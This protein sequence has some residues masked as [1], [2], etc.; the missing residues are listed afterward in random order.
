[1]ATEKVVTKV[2]YRLKNGTSTTLPLG[3]TSDYIQMDN[4]EQENLTQRL[5]ILEEKTDTTIRPKKLDILEVQSHLDAGTIEQYCK[6]GDYVELNPKGKGITKFY[7]IGINGHNGQVSNHIYK[8]HIDFYGG[9]TATLNSSLPEKNYG[10]GESPPDAAWKS[11]VF[12]TTYM[13]GSDYNEG[14]EI[15]NNFFNLSESYS[16]LNFAPKTISYDERYTAKKTVAALLEYF[17][18]SHDES[19]LWVLWGKLE[20]LAAFEYDSNVDVDTTNNTITLGEDFKTAITTIKTDS[21]VSLKLLRASVKL[22]PNLITFPI[23]A[24]DS[25]VA[26][27]HGVGLVTTDIELTQLYDLYMRIHGWV[28]TNAAPEMTS[29]IGK[30]Q[31]S[32]LLWMLTEEEIDNNNILGTP[33]YTALTGYCYPFFQNKQLF[34]L[35]FPSSVSADAVFH[36]ITPVEGSSTTY[37]SW[38]LDSNNVLTK[39]KHRPT[40]NTSVEGFGFR[41]ESKSN[42]IS[43]PS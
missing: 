17:G 10:N 43:Y 22:E 14:D 30:A 23:S 32:H 38:Q 35:L 7:V 33:Q 13:N 2:K 5:E 25:L 24:A 1:M 12:Y 27:R 20:D 21:E 41:L 4:G 18:F 40:H 11:T 28:L 6:I 29:S 9:S 36:S 39:T 37:V 15:R 8:D 16:S 19:K 34:R 42:L 31:T 3:T 26:L